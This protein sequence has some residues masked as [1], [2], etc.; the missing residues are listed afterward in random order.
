MQPSDTFFYFDGTNVVGPHTSGEL[1]E[2]YHGKV[3][4]PETQV[5]TS[6]DHG[7]KPLSAFP[8]LLAER[9]KATRLVTANEPAEAGDVQEV[10]A[11]ADAG[12]DVTMGKPG[13]KDED[14]DQEDDV[15]KRFTPI[16]SIRSLLNDLWEAQRESII[17]QVKNE[18]LDER[19]EKKRK[20]HLEI[21]ENVRDMVLEYWRRSGVLDDWINDLIWKGK[22]GEW[23]DY[24]KKLKVG[25][26]HGNFE[27]VMEWLDNSDL[28]KLAGVYSFR[29]GKKRIYIGQS[30][31]LKNR[32]KQHEGQ[33]F[34]GEATH[35]R[36]LI[37]Q[38]M[39]SREKLERL[40]ILRHQPEDNGN[41][42]ISSSGSKADE[43]LDFIIK[44]INELLT[45][46]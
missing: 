19:Y 41:K 28:G 30:V 40:M 35:L 10:K 32:M 31:N 20:E 36:I 26:I 5:C 12:K 13:Q 29:N 27:R 33:Y 45:D 7:W 17:A 18:E 46:G 9:V 23:G 38:H 16:K 39:A 4:T 15:A 3:I 14:D 2:L 37:P 24:L 1:S 25:D 42:G 22:N 8:H 21:K 6:N 34:W 11:G 44:E 43:V